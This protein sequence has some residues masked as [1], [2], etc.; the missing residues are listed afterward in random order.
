[1]QEDIDWIATH[2]EP[3][4]C[5]FFNPFRFANGD[6]VDLVCGTWL[7]NEYRVQHFLADEHLHGVFSIVSG[8]DGEDFASLVGMLIIS[9]LIVVSRRYYSKPDF[10]D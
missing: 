10:N 2:R 1:M 7:R 5:Q 3:V 8:A 9:S 4:S 6:K